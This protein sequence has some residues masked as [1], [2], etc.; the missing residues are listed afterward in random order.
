VPSR[1]KAAYH[2]ERLFGYEIS[3]GECFKHPE[4]LGLN[5]YAPRSK[6]YVK[7]GLLRKFRS[8]QTKEDELSKLWLFST[9][10]KTHTDKKSFA[11]ER[12]RA[13]ELKNVVYYT[14]YDEYYNPEIIESGLAYQGNPDFMLG[15]YQL[16]R[17]AD[18]Q[19]IVLEGISC[20][21]TTKGRYPKRAANEM[22]KYLL[23][24]N[25]IESWLTGGY[26]IESFFYRE[27]GVT[28]INALL[29]E[30]LRSTVIG[31][32]P[33]VNKRDGKDAILHM[34]D[35]AGK[36]FL[37]KTGISFQDP[38]NIEENEDVVQPE[39]EW[40]LSD[41]EDNLL[42]LSDDDVEIYY[43]DEEEDDDCIVFQ[44]DIE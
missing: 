3:P 12:K 26:T 17:W 35:G 2:Y 23:A 38:P 34:R 32:F 43:V 20:G 21:R 10:W 19:G 5:P 14:E 27:P 18:L 31:N 7:G 40:D 28:G 37:A 16:P 6:G 15:K 22:L 41:E 42:D 33:S 1:W 11:L 36:D 9:P 4:E 39:E 13:K 25:P 8:P 44:D 29:Y 24:P 30:R